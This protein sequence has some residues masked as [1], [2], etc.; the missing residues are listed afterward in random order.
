MDIFWQYTGY[1]AMA[2]GV[3]IGVSLVLWA[4]FAGIR[5]L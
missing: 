2:L 5:N 4:F 1:G 3:G